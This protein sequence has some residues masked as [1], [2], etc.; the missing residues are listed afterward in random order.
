MSASH[1]PAVPPCLSTPLIVRA[2]LAAALSIAISASG[3]CG[4]DP[5][6][7]STGD[8]ADVGADPGD[9]TGDAV[10]DGGDDTT[11]ADSGDDPSRDLDGGGG[12]AETDG[13]T[14]DTGDDAESDAE[15]T[16]LAPPNEPPPFAAPVVDEPY[17]QEYNHTTPEVVAGIGELVAVVEARDGD[18]LQ[19]TPRAVF[20]VDGGTPTPLLA[21]DEGAASLAWASSDGDAAYVA[22]RDSVWRLDGDAADAVD[23]GADFPLAGLAAA[24]GGVIA[25]G[26]AGARWVTGATS[27]PLFD[28]ATEAVSAYGDEVW[29]AQGLEVRAVSWRPGDPSLGDE[30]WRVT[31]DAAGGA[32]VGIV[33]HVELVGPYDAVVVQSDRVVAVRGGALASEPLFAD[34]FVPLAGPYQAAVRTNDGGFIIATPRGA[35]RVIDWDGPEWHLYRAERWLPG[36]DVRGVAVG[37]GDET[38]PVWF[39]TSGGLATVTARYETLEQKL[40][41]FVDRVLAR[42]NREGAVADS[43]LVRRGDVT[44]NIP[45]DSD[46][47]GGW[48]SYWLLAECA[49]WRVTGDAGARANFDEALEAMLRLHDLTGTTWFLA[50]AVIRREGCQLDDCDDPDDGHWFLSP[51]EDFW[52]KADTSNDEVAAHIFMMGPAYDLCATPEQKERIA[53]HI[54][55]IV[56]GIVDNG[57]QLLDLDGLVTTYGQFDP[58]YVN[59]SL[60]G[61]YGDGGV[62]SV[63][64]IGSLNIAYY[65]TSD[66][67]YLDAKRELIEEFG[68][69]DNL[70]R[71]ATYPGRRGNGDADELG[72]YGWFALLRYETDPV[73]RARWLDGWALTRQHLALQQGA[74]WDVAN[75]LVG[76]PDVD[77][78]NTLRWLRRAPVDMVRWRVA[79]SDRRDLVTAPGFYQFSGYVRRDG[80]I[81]PYD[82]RACDRWNTNQFKRDG[83]FDGWVE[84]DGADVLAPYWLARAYGLIL[85]A[86]AD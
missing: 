31:L 80:R 73:L 18:A 60:S 17:L 79:N 49:R 29:I 63:E 83:G 30:R 57:Y 54:D 14:D 45:W 16:P 58:A 40:G 43:H 7:D 32:L 19:V 68:Y 53:H 36:D 1:R 62:R 46:N 23:L 6:G 78:T 21:L 59:D 41:P 33:P 9:V 24:D 20:R 50:R 81:I 76:G 84:M 47:D 65:L 71:E 28:G 12:D 4:D 27:T 5:G 75:A 3:G 82:E 67:R 77:M 35:Q 38:A 10:T 11:D 26:A 42:H 56:G 69:G 39:A 22:S 13:D 85:E 37:R 15:V 55:A 48:T 70:V 51:D 61:R 8:V 64:M 66:P 34:D 52:V 86:G 74:W 44:S 25:F 72:T 2:R